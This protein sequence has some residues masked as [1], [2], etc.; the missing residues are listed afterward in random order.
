MNHILCIHS[1]A[2]GY[3][4]WLCF[5]VEWCSSTPGYTSVPI[6]ALGGLYT[7]ACQ[8]RVMS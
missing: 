6:I 2:D 3:L 5:L 7:Q 4:G 8:K 1:S